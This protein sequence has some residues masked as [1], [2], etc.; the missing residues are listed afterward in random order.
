MLRAGVCSVTFRKLSAQEVIRLAAQAGL[1]GIEWGGD[2][3]VPHGDLQT[4]REVARQTREA[5]LEVSSYGSYYRVGH[6][7]ELPFEKVLATAKELGAPIVRV[8]AGKQ[9]S[10]EASPDYWQQVVEDSRHIAQSASREGITLCYEFHPGT[11]ADTG[12]STQRLLESVAHPAMRTYWQPEVEQSLLPNLRDLRTLLPWLVNVHTFWWSS[13]G[14]RCPL[15]EGEKAWS[16]FL[17][18]IRLSQR[19]HWILLEFVRADS[20]E[21]FLQDALTLQQWLNTGQ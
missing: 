8:W 13:V 1:Q 7:D 9:G 14:E 4:A 19:E 5:G 18:V 15:R 17:Q 21:A 10:R 6:G 20:P 12:R 11:L 16:R 3:H 2:I